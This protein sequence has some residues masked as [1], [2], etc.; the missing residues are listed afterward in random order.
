M[1]VKRARAVT[2]KVVDAWIAGV[3]KLFQESGLIKRGRVDKDFS[4]RLW[5][6]NETAFAHLT[7][8]R[9]CLQKEAAR[10]CMRLVEEVGGSKSLFS[11]LVQHLVS[12]FLHTLFT[13]ANISTTLGAGVDQQV[14][15]I[16]LV[17]VVGLNRQI[18]YHGLRNFLFQQ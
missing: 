4:N 11:V 5:N 18:F 10:R 1:S 2:P 12:S 6:C 17:T 14:H 13:D 16:E 8:Q 3:K 9:R 7:H 15:Y